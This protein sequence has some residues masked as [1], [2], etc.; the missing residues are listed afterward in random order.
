MTVF[1]LFATT[2]HPW[3]ICMPVALAVFTPF[4]YA[5]IWSFTATLSYAAYQYNPVQENLWLI[6]GGYVLCW[7][8]PFGN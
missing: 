8:M 7:L 6:G 1:F 4:R 5:F 3:Y 2:V